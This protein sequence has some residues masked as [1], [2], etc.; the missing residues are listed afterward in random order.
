M[1]F[2]AGDYINELKNITVWTSTAPLASNQGKFRIF[3]FF[4]NSISSCKRN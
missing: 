3:P 4:F 1:L 2:R